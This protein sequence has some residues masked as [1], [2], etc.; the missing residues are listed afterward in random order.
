MKAQNAY[1]KLIRYTYRN[2]TTQVSG[3]Q[4][5]SL[6][7]LYAKSIDTL[8]EGSFTLLCVKYVECAKTGGL[9]DAHTYK[10]VPIKQAA[11]YKVSEQL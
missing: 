10:D 2:C 11:V 8:P 9:Q 7:Q 3:G 5:D 6:T 1:I 4:G